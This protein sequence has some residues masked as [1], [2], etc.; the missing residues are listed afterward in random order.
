MVNI[1]DGV[2]LPN[3]D[4]YVNQHVSDEVGHS[5]VLLLQICRDDSCFVNWIGAKFITSILHSIGLC[6]FSIGIF[7]TA[8]LEA[9]N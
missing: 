2:N 5:F 9:K 7:S 1:R 4:G 6:F 8:H 3:A